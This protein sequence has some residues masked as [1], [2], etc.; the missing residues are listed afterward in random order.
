MIVKKR[1]FYNFSNYTKL[2]KWTQSRR[3]L[4]I[5]WKMYQVNN[6]NYDQL[7]GCK[8]PCLD[9]LPIRPTKPNPLWHFWKEKKKKTEVRNSNVESLHL[10]HGWSNPI[11]ARPH[12][13][14]CSHHNPIRTSEFFFFFFP[15]IFSFS[16]KIGFFLNV[17]VGDEVNG[18]YWADFIGPQWEHRVSESQIRCL[19]IL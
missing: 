12:H 8:W 1:L 10:S 15:I 18:G 5:L 19:N 14:M 11:C 2:L 16:V 4:K 3:L 17:W 6:Q 7:F 13:N 9:L